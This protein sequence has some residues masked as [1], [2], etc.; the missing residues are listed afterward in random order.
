MKT[1]WTPLVLD[2]RVWNG[3]GELRWDSQRAA[4]SNRWG[5]RYVAYVKACAAWASQLQRELPEGTKSEDIEYSLFMWA[6]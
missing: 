5:D 6:S 4:D 2:S 3:L 1:A